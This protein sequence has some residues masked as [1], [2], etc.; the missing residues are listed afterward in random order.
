MKKICVLLMCLF[1]IGAFAQISNYCGT[2]HDEESDKF[3][4]DFLAG[5]YVQK[6]TMDI[7]WVPMTI[8]LVSASDGTPASFREKEAGIALCQ[9][10]VDFESSGIQFYLSSFNYILNDTYLNHTSFQQGNQMMTFN[11]I[12][13]TVNSYFV[14]DPAGTCGYFSP[15][16]GAVAMSFGCS[17]PNSHTW[18]HEIGHYFSLPH[19]FRGWE[20]SDYEAG[21]I[22]PNAIG[23]NLVERVENTANCSNQADR[24]CDTPADYLSF[25][26]TCNGSQTSNVT[27]TDPDTVNFTSDGTYFMS[28]ANDACMDKFSPMQEEAMVINLE[29]TKP[30]QIDNS[31][32]P[33]EL[34]LQNIF[35]ISP[36]NDE[37]ISDD[38]VLL[39]WDDNGQDVIGYYVEIS[40][41]EGFNFFVKED[42]VTETSYMVYD[43][44]DN[45]NYYWRITPFSRSGFCYEPI[46]NTFQT[47][48]VVSTEELDNDLNLVLSPNPNNGQ[49]NLASAIP[50]TG[51]INV[52]NLH[53][54]LIYSGSSNNTTRQSIELNVPAG[55]Y[56]LQIEQKGK[57]INKKFIVQ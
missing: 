26:W 8:H 53:N 5:K 42:F 20:G 25:R 21:D 4:S 13:G 39:E 33:V 24:F 57:K 30:N 12:N 34:D 52:Y 28:Y 32:Q 27:Q 16:G 31:Y 45:K 44:L 38:D 22:A 7:T 2:E 37:I 1:S 36:I 55:L 46:L 14:S 50:F 41:L 51:K 43:L 49:F 29:E 47:S 10:N 11:N 6:N 15:S 9:L 17:G 48:F 23:G 35:A 18:A 3:I 19:T 40:R 56:I 54:Q